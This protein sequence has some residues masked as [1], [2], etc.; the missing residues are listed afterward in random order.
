MGIKDSKPGPLQPLIYL[1]KLDRI[2]DWG[3]KNSIWP[4][5]WG[6]ACCA[7]EMMAT[8]ASRFDLDRFGIL[9]GFPSPRQSDTIIVAGTVTKKMAP[10]IKRLYEQMPEP[11]YVI[12]M[13]NCAVSGEF[14]ITTATRS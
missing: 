6:L 4:L 8:F 11:K 12:A 10:V 7:I 5:P 2:F 13:G 9:G 3:R 1:T 14:T